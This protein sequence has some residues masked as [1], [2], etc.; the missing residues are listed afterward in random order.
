MIFKSAFLHH[1]IFLHFLFYLLKE[2]AVQPQKEIFLSLHDTLIYFQVLSK[3]RSLKN[4]FLG[5]GHKLRKSTMADLS[6]KGI[7]KNWGNR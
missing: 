3:H 2:Y 6:S 4:F 1:L 7:V 5:S